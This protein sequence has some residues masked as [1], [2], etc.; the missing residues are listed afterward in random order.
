M[1]G[2]A[3]GDFMETQYK[4]CPKCTDWQGKPSKMTEVIEVGF[5]NTIEREDSTGIH[6]GWKCRV[7]SAW[8]EPDMPARKER[9]ITPYKVDR[10][11]ARAEVLRHIKQIAMWRRIGR[12]WKDIVEHLGIQLSPQT[13]NRYMAEFNIN[14][15]AS[16]VVTG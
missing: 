8:V 14:M 12:P 15:E 16:N 7:C 3:E 10:K 11:G 2:G 4:P 5:G 1:E 6:R 13:V 9:A